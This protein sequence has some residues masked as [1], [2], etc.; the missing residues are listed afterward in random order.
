MGECREVWMCSLWTKRLVF[1][2]TARTNRCRCLLLWIDATEEDCCSPSL[3]RRCGAGCRDDVLLVGLW[4]W[5]YSCVSPADTSRKLNES[6]CIFMNPIL[7]PP[8]FAWCESWK[9]G[10][11]NKNMARVLSLRFCEV[12]YI[13]IVDWQIWFKFLRRDRYPSS[14]CMPGGHWTAPPDYVL[15]TGILVIGMVELGA[16]SCNSCFCLSNILLQA[17]MSL[18]IFKGFEFSLWFLS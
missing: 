11:S 8:E 5:W 12:T 1:G 13:G 6:F 3:A 10:S 4:F 2:W 9:Q 14:S 7:L 17:T 15:L 16:G 18:L